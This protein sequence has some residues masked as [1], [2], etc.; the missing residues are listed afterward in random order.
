[1]HGGSGMSDDPISAQSQVLT[2]WKH[3]AR[4]LN[5]GVR[6][7][8]RY[9]GEEELPIRRLTGGPRGTVVATKTELDDWLAARPKRHVSIA[10]KLLPPDSTI[11]PL[12]VAILRMRQLRTEMKQRRADVRTAVRTLH[13]RI[14]LVVI[15]HLNNPVR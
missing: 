7:I 12:G 4:Y 11:E 8:Q 14:Q 5:M 15:T 6:T 10:P 2:G 1:L 3:I 9:E 13:R